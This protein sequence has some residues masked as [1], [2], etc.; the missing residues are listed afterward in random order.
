LKLLFPT[1]ELLLY[2]AQKRKVTVQQMRRIVILNVSIVSSEWQ[3]IS[4]TVI[5]YT[6][7][8]D[9]GKSLQKQGKSTC[10]K[11]E[12]AFFFNRLAGIPWALLYKKKTAGQPISAYVI[13][14]LH[15][16]IYKG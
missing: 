11:Q 8:G 16:D 4:H 9:A 3:F 10:K 1:G 14:S 13:P 12:K 6:P 7:T 5:F 2:L 15:H